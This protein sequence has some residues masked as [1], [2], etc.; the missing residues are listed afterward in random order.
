MITYDSGCNKSMN[1]ITI[2]N[3]LNNKETIGFRLLDID[4]R[5]V[6]EVSIDK[7]K[8]AI[9]HNK[10][11]ID[12]LVVEDNN[13]VG[14]NGSIDKLPKLS[15]GQLI[16][17][18]PLIIIS[19]IGNVG[20]KVCDY[21][22]NIVNLKEEDI[23]KYGK[24]TG[25]ANGQIVNR[26]NKEYIRAISGSY[27]VERLEGSASKQLVYTGEVVKDRRQL[28]PILTVDF[29][30]DYGEIVYKGGNYKIH[31]IDKRLINTG[32][33]KD[34]VYESDRHTLLNEIHRWLFVDTDRD[35]IIELLKG[36]YIKNSIDTSIAE[37]KKVYKLEEL[38]ID[39]ETGI[40]KP[41]NDTE[42]REIRVQTSNINNFK[43]SGEELD[44]YLRYLKVMNVGILLV[45]EIKSKDICLF[46]RCTTEGINYTVFSRN[47][48]IKYEFRQ[49]NLEYVYYN[50][51]EY[52][53][54]IVDGKYMTVVGLDGVYR[55]DMDKISKQYG[56]EILPASIKKTKANM[57]GID[58]IEIISA[59]G[60][61]I[62]IGNVG[63]NLVI[64]NNV[65]NILEYSIILTGVSR[66]T[67][68]SHIES[69][70]INCFDD[71][72]DYGATMLE[73]IEIGSK[74]ASADIF[75]SIIALD[76]QFSKSIVINF[77]Y[78]I[79]PE[80]FID[81]I[82]SSRY[83]DR[84]LVNGNK[85]Y[86][87]DKFAWGVIKTLLIDEQ[88]TI[89]LVNKPFDVINKISGGN[90]QV[91]P[92]DDYYEFWHQFKSIIKIWRDVLRVKVSK[93]MDTKFKNIIHQIE[94]THKIRKKELMDRGVDKSFLMTLK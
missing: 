75:D 77:T 16:E 88:Q 47:K 54:V 20:Y 19:R 90:T 10:V 55:Y 66:I 42:Y 23:I 63:S 78:D 39:S 76:R 71:D 41:E 74:T 37:F 38:D 17:R 58:Y 49:Y 94:E 28:K 27:R 60:D 72:I 40:Y 82:Y 6:T 70:S 4:T 15:H 5:E 7:L 11:T 2:A 50:H 53:N 73:Y 31:S 22:G 79:T 18:A 85:D 61:L 87:D 62:K 13:I 69:C 30:L 89:G 65:K 9:L 64:P 93:D 14:S 81:K 84:V 83:V 24:F 29:T 91:M 21:R 92:S 36:G 3:I 35:E 51:L 43:V 46:R 59:K 32:V 26:D 86:I 48:S 8:K 1:I 57:L 45:K 68:G 67:F 33:K 34:L 80:F 44:K 56:R 25:L 52:D 12:N